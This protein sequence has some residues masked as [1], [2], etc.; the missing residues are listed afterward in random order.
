M[1]VGRL[2]PRLGRLA[3]NSDQVLERLC[4]GSQEGFGGSLRFF[5][6][7]SASSLSGSCAAGFLFG[8]LAALREN[9]D[10]SRVDKLPFNAK[11]NR[12]V[13]FRLHQS[14]RA[15]F[16]TVLGRTVPLSRRGELAACFPANPFPPSA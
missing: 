6:V 15:S 10:E 4:L 9:K 5:V 7:V 14:G 8:L 12:S 16:S 2:K 13:D 1:I 11:A 3:V